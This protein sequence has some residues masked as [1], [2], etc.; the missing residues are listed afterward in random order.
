[1]PIPS[2]RCRCR[3]WVVHTYFVCMQSWI[4]GPGIQGD[5]SAGPGRKRQGGADGQCRP[6][7]FMQGRG[8]GAGCLLGRIKCKKGETR[9]QAEPSLLFS[10]LLV[11]NSLL[12]R[13]PAT[14][15]A[16]CCRHRSTSAR[17]RFPVSTLCNA[18]FQL[19][20]A[21]YSC[22]L[23]APRTATQQQLCRPLRGISV[24]LPSATTGT[25]QPRH[26]QRESWDPPHRQ[27]R[28]HLSE[29][30]RLTQLIPQVRRQLISLNQHNPGRTST[31]SLRVC[32]SELDDCVDDCC[33]CSFFSPLASR[34]QQAPHRGAARGLNPLGAPL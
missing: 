23:P 20:T 7:S 16:F 12:S 22:V 18:A 3:G 24:C 14:R 27:H 4:Q 6:K 28:T 1:M 11:F 8:K 32:W 19:I 21:E 25:R 31:T 5:R 17:L 9:R 10:I 30:L 15:P 26:Q 29:C 34:L 2:R 33:G 13:Q